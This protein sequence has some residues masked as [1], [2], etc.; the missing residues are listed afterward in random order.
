[1]QTV[2]PNATV[3][4]VHWHEENKCEKMPKIHADMSNVYM[5]IVPALQ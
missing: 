3:N 5:N 2:M 4:T 1:M